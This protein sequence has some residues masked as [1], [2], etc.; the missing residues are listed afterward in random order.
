MN[1]ILVM[2]YDGFSMYEISPLTSILAWSQ[3]DWQIDVVAAEHKPYQTEDGFEVIPQMTFEDVQNIQAYQML[4][5]PGIANYHT[6]LP[7]QRNIA[8][9]SRF[10]TRPRPVI[11]VISASPILL[12]KAGLLDDTKFVAGLFESAY[13]EERF[14]LKRNLVRKPVV[15]DNGIVTST[16]FFPREFGVTAAHAIGVNV[17]KNI[18]EQFG[19]DASA[20]DLTFRDNG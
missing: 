1:K 13:E 18:F 16:A 20:E 12:A 7:N 11:A 2:I 17:P 8:F 19:T 15:S 5:M 4:V 3:T 6:V 10:K 9:L 14:I